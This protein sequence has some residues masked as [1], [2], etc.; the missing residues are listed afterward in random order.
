MISHNWWI[1]SINACHQLW[2]KL[3]GPEMN[4]FPLRSLV[5]NKFVALTQSSIFERTLGKKN[6]GLHYNVES[7]YLGQSLCIIQSGFEKKYEFVEV[8]KW[9]D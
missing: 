7:N 9:K 5:Q 4:F 8:G 3:N 1:P 2:I 6:S